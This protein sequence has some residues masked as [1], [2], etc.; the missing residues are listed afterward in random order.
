MA[1][2]WEGLS[3]FFY[4]GGRGGG[5]NFRLI[6]KRDFAS[7]NAAPEGMWVQGGEIKL[8][9]VRTVFRLIPVVCVGTHNRR[10]LCH[11]RCWDVNLV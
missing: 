1:F 10:T 9:V 3:I 4:F 6:F 8:P 11:N 7:E 5:A 2:S